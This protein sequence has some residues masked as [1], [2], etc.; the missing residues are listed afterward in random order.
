[1][2]GTSGAG[3]EAPVSLT[4]RVI[5]SLRMKFAGFGHFPTEAHWQGL[6][7]LAGAIED[8]ASGR[9]KS[10]FTYSALP[11]GM[12]KTSVMVEAVRQ[13]LADPA[14]A[15][16]GIVIF[17]HQLDHIRLLTRELEL[18][19]PLFDVNS[20]ER[21]F[22]VRT[23]RANVD[24]NQMGRGHFSKKTPGKWLSDHASA[25]VLFATQAK[26]LAVAQGDYTHDFEDFWKYKGKPR[27]VRIWDESILPAEPSA[28]TIRQIDA[29]AAKLLVHGEAVA[30]KKLRD[31]IEATK[32]LLVGASKAIE[33]PDLGW[34]VK[35][36]W[37]ELAEGD[38]ILAALGEQSGKVVRMVSDEFCGVTS[39]HY[40]E[41]LPDNLAPMLILDASG[42]LRVTYAK[43]K[44]GRGN[45][46]ELPS[47]GKTYRNLTIHHWEHPAGKAAYRDPEK[48]EK[49]ALAVLCAFREM[50][51]AERLLVIH[52]LPE[53]PSTNLALKVREMFDR[54]G[55]IADLEA[56]RVRFL[57]W[58]RH[59][60]SNEF[61]TCKNVLVVGLLQYNWPL[62]EAYLRAAGKMAPEAAAAEGEVDQLRLGEVA[63]HLFQGVGRGAVRRTVH[64]DVPPG[65]RLWCVFSGMGRMRVPRALLEVVFPGAA[66]HAWEPLGIQLRDPRHQTANR[67]KL[68][69]VLLGRL[70]ELSEIRFELAGLTEFT[71]PTAL[72]LVTDARVQEKLGELGLALHKTGDRKVGRARRSVYVLS[73]RRCSTPHNK[74]LQRLNTVSEAEIIGTPPVSRK[75]ALEFVE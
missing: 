35:G 59:M 4:S 60:A 10:V 44:A 74:I 73:R 19:N 70:G 3:I 23:G 69:A 14:Y 6:T 58:G 45:L 27:Q 26:L 40:H 34:F 2:S 1:M 62:N 67:E 17:T 11:T 37:Q 64:G 43:W 52:H 49:L 39:L 9:A 25:Q 15:E 55:L 66:I 38:P 18:L 42:A 20:W 53:K 54:A 63:H 48:L 61:A 56:G 8:M 32:G 13:M 50:P 16:I 7:A 41:I 46:T 75:S 36:D 24:L 12:G 57:T 65:C 21:R 33:F 47:P 31:W 68:I 28:I 30:A 71:R 51:V 5:M 22:A 29:V 72:R